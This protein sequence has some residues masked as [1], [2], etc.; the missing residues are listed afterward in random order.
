MQEIFNGIFSGIRITDV[1]DILIVAFAIYKLLEFIRET[2][3]AQLVKGLLVLI[4]VTFVSEISHLY[5]I[6][7]ILRNTMTIGV[8]ALV[9]IFQPELRRGLEYLGRSKFVPGNFSQINKDRAKYITSEF[10]RAVES[11][12]QTKTGALIIIERETALTDI[13]ETGTV[14]DAE[15]SSEILGNIFTRERLFTTALL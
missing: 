13:I 8:V 2:R 11:F 14:V 10:I 6:N 9:I 5:T 7:W 3:A 15:I 4:V 12:S 1:I